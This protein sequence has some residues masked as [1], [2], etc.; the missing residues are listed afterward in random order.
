MICHFNPIET[1]NN[2]PS[3]LFSQS[4]VFSVFISAVNRRAPAYRR[5]ASRK[6]LT[7]NST[8]C[9]P[10]ARLLEAGALPAHR[11]VPVGG[12]YL[13]P[14]ARHCEGWVLSAGI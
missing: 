10:S 8:Q 2:I 13:F 6:G 7:R 5:Q 1:E 14:V 11:K 9:L 12:R 4:S 3:F